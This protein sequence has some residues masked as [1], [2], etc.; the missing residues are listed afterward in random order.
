[1]RRVWTQTLFLTTFIVGTSAAVPGQQQAEQ[2]PP[3]FE[4]ASVKPNTDVGATPTWLNGQSGSVRITAYRVRQLIAIAYDSNAI[5][6]RDQIVG[7]PTWLDSDRFDIVAKANGSLDADETGRP[8]RLLAMLRS[9]LEDRFKLRMHTE[10]RKAGVYLLTPARKDGRIGSQLHRSSQQECR[11]PVGSLVPADSVHWCGWR[12]FGTGHYTIQGLTMEDMARGFASAWSIGR[13]VLDH[14]GLSG[15]WDAQLD[16]V[17]TFVQGPNPD[18]GPVQN[19][20]ADSGPDMVSALRDQL[21]LK[22]EGGKAMIEH[23]VIDH[24]ERPSAD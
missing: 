11:G 15:R 23:F 22:L 9:L 17:P 7:G 19:P 14:T 6:T 10:H 18:S 1:M 5:Q 12:G 4:V 16:F 8:T 21:G 2:K 20:A 13:P 3:A 24:V